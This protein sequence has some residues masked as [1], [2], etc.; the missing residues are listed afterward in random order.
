MSR[1]GFRKTA[2]EILKT[3]ADKLFLV[4]LYLTRIVLMTDGSILNSGLDSCALGDTMLAIY[5]ICLALCSV[6]FMFIFFFVEGPG[7]KNTHRT[8]QKCD[9]LY[10]YIE[11]YISWR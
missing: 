2:P 5:L 1:T 10:L 11:S 8:Q 3:I 7:Q 6:L 9:F 4:A